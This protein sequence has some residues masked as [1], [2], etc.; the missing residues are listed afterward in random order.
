MNHWFIIINP[1]AQS[2]RAFEEWRKIAVELQKQGVVY[3]YA[4]TKHPFHA[5][6]LVE[7]ALKM[8]F[9]KIAAVGGDG[10]IHEV[11]NGIMMQQLE[12]TTEIEF[13]VIAAGTGSDWIKTHKIPKQYEQAVA[14]LKNGQN[15]L[16]DVGFIKY[17]LN[18]QEVSRYF[19]NVAGMAYDAYVA[20]KLLGMPRGGLSGEVFYLLS[21][22]RCMK[23][24]EAMEM[25][26]KGDDFEYE[27]KVFCL[28]VGI[29]RYSAGGMQIVPRSIPD[30]GL[31]DVTIIEDLSFLKVL[32]NIPRLY[33][34]SIYNAPQAKHFRTKTLEIQSDLSLVEAEGEILGKA[35]FSFSILP[36]MLNLKVP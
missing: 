18:E 35:P 16:Q 15:T 2:G 19:F 27:G 9:R 3:E 5:P 12:P 4:F 7:N 8:G 29:C 10:T 6:I 36:K 24:Y 26:I 34:G 22:L 20:E 14:T 30:D 11:A 32:R 25:R 1:N 17:R 33:M 21:I 13:G 28:N 31:F 23:G